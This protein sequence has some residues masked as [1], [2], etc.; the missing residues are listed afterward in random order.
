MATTPEPASATTPTTLEGLAARALDRAADRQAME[1][2]GRWINW[3]EVRATADQVGAL[4]EASGADPAAP[5]AFL[6]R[7]RPEFLTTL[8]QLLKSRR[9]IRMLYTFQSPAGMAADIARL[10][11]AIAIA[12]EQDLTEPVLAQL[13]EQ[14]VATIMLRSMTASAVPGLERSANNFD[15]D[16][17]PEPRIEI[18]TSG[19]TGAPKHFP[20]PYSQLVAQTLGANSV[21]SADV[22]TSTLPPFQLVLPLGNIGGLYGAI[23]TLIH[24]VRIIVSER[25]TFEGWLDYVIRYPAKVMVLPPAGVRQLLDSDVQPSD[26]AGIRYFI[27]GAAPVDP[28][29]IEEVRARYGISIMQS[30]GATEFGGVVSQMTPDLVETFGP[31]KLTSVGRPIGEVRIRIVDGDSGETLPTG[32]IG[33]VHVL[34]PKMG[35]EWRTTSDLGMLDEDGFLYLRG[36]AD[37]AIMRGGFKLLPDTITN[38]LVTHPAISAAAVV[39]IPERRLGQVPVAALERAAGVAEPS[40]AEIEAWL[41]DR[42][43]STHI[44]VQ[45]RWFDALPRNPSLKPDV[46]TIRSLFLEG[47]AAG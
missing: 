41:R 25:F 36:R 20:L 37:G 1:F 42:V 16:G 26:L 33:A 3:G 5:V 14:G 38:A 44:P 11:P 29:A 6:A 43:P 18:L 31:S 9:V 21:F 39:G 24:G 17:S 7:M 32:Q 8:L 22:D 40:I 12:A 34:V 46:L 23:P 30:Y 2:E 15:R 45:W 27:C 19:T 47:D 4:I 13:R 35:D 10:R 28:S